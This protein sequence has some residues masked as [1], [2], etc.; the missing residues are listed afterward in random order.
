MIEKNKYFE[1]ILKYIKNNEIPLYINS[2]P[3][4]IYCF[5]LRELI[6]V[7]I[8]DNRMPKTTEFTLNQQVEKTYSLINIKKAKKI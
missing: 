8:T 4:G 2:T 1:L 3:S 6:P 5:D 7:W